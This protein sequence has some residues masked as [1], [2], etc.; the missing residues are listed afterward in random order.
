[1]YEKPE[2]TLVGSA[3]AVVLGPI[4][5]D[6]DNELFTQ[7]LAAGLVQ[8]LSIDPAALQLNV[9]GSAHLCWES[10]DPAKTAPVSRFSRFQRRRW[11]D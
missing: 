4:G 8:G 6:D 7:E 11:S 1:M 10:S 9:T 5:A 2:L 3:A